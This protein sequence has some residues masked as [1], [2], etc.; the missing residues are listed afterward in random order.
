MNNLNDVNLSA[1]RTAR[2]A[3][4]VAV[5]TARVQAE[6]LRTQIAAAEERCAQLEEESKK[7]ME[8]LENM[9]KQLEELPGRAHG[10]RNEDLARGRPARR[11]ADR[12]H[13]RADAARRG[14]ENA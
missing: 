7:Q 2:A 3:Q 6:E 9:Q 4:A 11:G 13:R 10:R 14:G 8:S 1:Q 12:A 5:E